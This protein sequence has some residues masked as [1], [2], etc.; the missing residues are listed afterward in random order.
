MNKL[1]VLVVVSGICGAALFSGT[2]PQVSGRADDRERL[3]SDTRAVRADQ[4]PS[5]QAAVDA[6][7]AEGGKV[8]LPPRT[9]EIT[10][11][12]RVTQDDVLIQGC[13]TASHIKNL[14]TAGQ[15]GLVLGASPDQDKDDRHQWR[16]TLAD[17]RLTG[18]KQSGHGIA[19]KNI[20]ELYID[21]ITV[22]ENGGDGIHLNRAYEDPRICDSLITYNAG[23]GLFLTGCHDIVVSA[24]QF[25]ENQDAVRCLDGYN[26]CMTG[27]NLDDHLGDGVVIENTYGSV[28]S[29]NMIEECQGTAIVLDR[30]CYG[31]TL[32]ANVIAHNQAGGID[33]RDAHG[34]AVSANTFTLVKRNAL[35]IGPSSGRI[36][37]TGNNFSDSF[38]GAA[39]GL[40]R[41]N[42][43]PAS[44][45]VLDGT[46]SVTVC[47]NLFSGLAT[48][49]II[50][51]E[52]SHNVLFANN[53]IDD[54]SENPGA[55]QSL[56]GHVSDNLIVPT[57][58]ADGESR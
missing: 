16:V 19:A 50:S 55:H 48:P 46:N 52:P 15:P 34:C 43:E 29:G 21:G 40:A 10:E 8:L 45:L 7:P 32:S 24:N 37:V 36:T 28:L 4:F 20:N 9:I 18:N 14:N 26:L 11:P 57:T 54:V 30:N 1:S 44:G 6:L 3:P 27:N 5:L 38:L 35:R 23:T 13:G 17:F 25:E 51:D 47:G 31:N 22:S 49:A 12:V 41:K 42:D 33:L 53:V 56:S 2:L 39:D 58:D